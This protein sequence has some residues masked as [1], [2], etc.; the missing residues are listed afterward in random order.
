VNSDEAAW[1]ELIARYDA[2]AD[3]LPA[4]PPWPEAED[5]PDSPASPQPTGS[6]PSPGLSPG[7]S[8]PPA[9]PPASPLPDGPLPD[10]PP[11]G[12]PLPG[13]PLPPASAGRA[14]IV[15][16]AAPPPPPPPLPALDPLA[17]GAWA[18]L[19]GGPAYLLIA[20]FLGWQIPSW[21]ALLAVAAFIGGFAIIILRMND[22]PPSDDDPHNGAVL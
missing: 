22:R 14:R 13:S 15:R 10:G 18:A 9:T 19:C 8:A 20:T 3:T 5:L 4:R 12:Q 7:S 17:K 2:P 1:R 11:A 16:S 21:A 6:A